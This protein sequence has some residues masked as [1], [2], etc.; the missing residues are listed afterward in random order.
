VSKRIFPVI[1]ALAL[2]T[3]SPVANAV[4]WE[5]GGLLGV[6]LPDENLTGAGKDAGEFPPTIGVRGDVYL[7]ENWGLFADG[8]FSSI[9]SSEEFGD[10][11]MLHGRVGAE[12]L[13]AGQSAEHAFYFGSGFGI[14]N[15]GLDDADSFDRPYW[16][17][18]LGKRWTLGEKTRLRFEV[19]GDRTLGTNED[20]A[21][22]RTMHQIEAVAGIS[23]LF[24]AS[25]PKTDTDRDG[26]WDDDDRCPDTPRG[27]KVDA[28]GCPSDADGDGVFDGIDKCPDTPKGATVDARGC[29]KDS[30]GDGVFDGIDQCPGTPKGTPVDARGCPT[31]EDGDG[32]LNENDKCP[33]TPKGVEVDETGCP[34]VAQLFQEEKKA[35]VLEGVNFEFNSATLTAASSRVLDRVAESMIAWP[36]VKVEV[37]GHT[38]TV[39]ARDYNVRLSERRA[40][41]VRDYL[42]S[43]GVAADRFQVKG[44]GPDAPV[45]GNDTEAGRAK[46]RR[47]E[48]QKR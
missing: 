37:G 27:A 26:V 43:K 2:A 12:L 47:V 17:L 48:L 21:I 9:G 15:V 8:L 20:E 42:V 19:R 25:A 1:A 4:P 31:D 3:H 6:Q 33:G 13:F 39:G 45:A 22:D 35:L 41:A 32:V 44:Y 30:D 28:A 34:K 7:T 24:G 38:D 36:D 14:M 10:A 29:P 40:A 18:G 11:T 23:W 5:V 16:S 46:N